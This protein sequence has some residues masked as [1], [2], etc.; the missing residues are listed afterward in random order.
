MLEALCSFKEY[1][2]FDK[3]TLM[4]CWSEQKWWRENTLPMVW[5]PEEGFHTHM[6][7][8]EVNISPW[9]HTCKA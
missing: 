4:A 6:E 8:G 5:N 2:Y 9:D 1:Q 7:E 3:E